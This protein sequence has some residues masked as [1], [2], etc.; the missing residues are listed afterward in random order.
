[1]IE[2]TARG[3]AQEKLLPRVIEA[4]KNEKFDIEI[5][6]DMG[7]LGFLGCSIDDYGLAG[8]SSVAYGKCT[9]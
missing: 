4:Y 7:A 3:Y 2:D 1:M 5:M 9:K 6:K 8:V